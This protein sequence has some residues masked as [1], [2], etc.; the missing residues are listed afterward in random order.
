MRFP[1]TSQPTPT[2]D[3]HL[4]DDVRAEVATVYSDEQIAVINATADAIIDAQ[5]GPGWREEFPWAVTPIYQR[6]PGDET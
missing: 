3:S 4:S 1:T 5:C 2:W 6:D